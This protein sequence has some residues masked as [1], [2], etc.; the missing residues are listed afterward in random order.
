VASAKV[1]SA[2]VASAKVASVTIKLQKTNN[3]INVIIT[4]LD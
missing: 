3:K 2:K 4:Q 1:A